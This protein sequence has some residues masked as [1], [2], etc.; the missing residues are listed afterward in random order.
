MKAKSARFTP[1][2]F[3]DR[4][5]FDNLTVALRDLN[6]LEERFRRTPR[7]YCYSQAADALWELGDTLRQQ[8]KAD[9][10]NPYWRTMPASMGAGRPN[11][12][13]DTIEGC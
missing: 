13:N 4:L 7:F 3:S 12:V 8:L 10:H 6:T 5:L 1:S 11:S 9:D 2:Y